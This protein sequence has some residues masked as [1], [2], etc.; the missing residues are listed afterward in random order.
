[1]FKQVSIAAIMLSA[2]LAM[3]AHAGPIPYP[4]IGT[5]APENSFTAIANG[6]V[7][8]YFFSSDASYKSR[9]GLW[10]SGTQIGNYG[11][12]NHTSNYGDSYLFGDVAAGDELVF[13]LQVLTTGG[14][15][16]SVASSNSDGLNHTYATDFA[17]DALIPAGTY[18]AFEDLPNLGDVDY[19]DHQF[20]FTNVTTTSSVP[21]PFSLALLGLGLAA[22]GF[23]RKRIT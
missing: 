2:S 16:Y 10:V 19:N 13:E 6:A 17:G 11:L 22:L 15:W 5:P 9:I 14:S 23:A 18:V 12:V 21:E 1:M 3:S 7:Y 4:N 20:V 8:A